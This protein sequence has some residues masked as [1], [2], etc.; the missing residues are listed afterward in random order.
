MNFSPENKPEP[1]PDGGFAE[2]LIDA[3]QGFLR[4]TRLFYSAVGDPYGTKC[5]TQEQINNL[6]H[7]RWELDLRGNGMGPQQVEIDLT[8]GMS[9]QQARQI[10]FLRL[11]PPKS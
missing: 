4:R 10:I 6:T 9:S 5:L 2:G 3:V 7:L 8:N 1:N 11:Y